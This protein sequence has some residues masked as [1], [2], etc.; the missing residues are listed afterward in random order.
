MSGS[1]PYYITTEFD[2]RPYDYNARSM[3]KVVVLM[4]DGENTS[5]HMLKDAFRSGPSP[6]WK[7]PSQDYTSAFNQYRSNSKKYWWQRDNSCHNGPDGG[8]FATQLTYP[9]FWHNYNVDFYEEEYSFLPDPMDV[10]GYDTKNTRLAAICSAAKAQNIE[11]F[12]IGF[13]TSSASSAIMQ[14]LRQL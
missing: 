4:T 12:T 7:H 3:Q 10:Y 6:I 1:A 5:Q 8:D 9:Q 2:D 11:I 14:R 13:E